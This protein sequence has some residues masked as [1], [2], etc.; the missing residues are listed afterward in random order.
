MASSCSQAHTR[1]KKSSVA[2]SERSF[3]ADPDLGPIEYVDADSGQNI[4]LS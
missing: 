2:D 1:K 3:D 4:T